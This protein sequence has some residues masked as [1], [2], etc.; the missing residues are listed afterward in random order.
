MSVAPDIR[1]EA[2]SV[3]RP[4]PPRATKY[5]RVERERR[6]L[7]RERPAD[8]PEGYRR[9]RDWYV[10]GTRLRLRRVEDPHGNVLD[11]KLGQKYRPAPG[12]GL[13]TT[14]TN[15]YLT[16][17]EFELL[18]RL[19]G[20]AIVK[21]RYSYCYAERDFSID[22]F[23]Q[24]LEGLVMAEIEFDSDDAAD[25]LAIP[26]FALA[27]VTSDPLFTGGVLARTT[28]AE[29]QQALARFGAR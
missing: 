3:M 1:Q 8:L 11:L 12:A 28:A 14:L 21:R 26:E 10:D 4:N 2:N 24:A 7:L 6:F 20:R 17:V 16:E 9:I 5:A 13:S 29:L 22:V 23:E 25:G 15:L 27:E 18:R 19:G